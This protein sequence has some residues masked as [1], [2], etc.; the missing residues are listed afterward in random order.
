MAYLFNP[1][2]CFFG[3]YLDDVRRPEPSKSARYYAW[4]TGI[5]ILI[6]VIGAF[7]IVGSP[8]QARLNQL[9]QQRINDLQNIQSQVVYYWQRKEQLPQNLSNLNDSISGYVNPQDPQT[10]EPYEYTIK[11]SKL[12]TFELCAVFS[13]DGN[14]R[15]GMKTMPAYPVYEGGVSQNWDHGQGRVCFERTIDKQLYPPIDKIR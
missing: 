5:V 4:A 9:D 8:N 14:T 15:G 6:L 13:L 10:S 2:Y 11:D 12:L 1:F 7:F 3:Y